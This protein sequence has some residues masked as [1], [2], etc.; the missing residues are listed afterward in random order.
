MNAR[1]RIASNYSLLLFFIIIQ[2]STE[3]GCQIR[4]TVAMEY[5]CTDHRVCLIRVDWRVLARETIGHDHLGHVD[6]STIGDGG[7]NSSSYRVE[8]ENAQTRFALSS[9]S[10]RLSE[11]LTTRRLEANESMW[12]S[13]RISE[14]FRGIV[15]NKSAKQASWLRVLQQI[16]IGECGAIYVFL[17]EPTTYIIWTG[18]SYAWI[19]LRISPRENVW[20]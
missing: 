19:K 16:Y 2:A 17:S 10:R 18:P 11:N 9:F 4:R 8:P 20:N 5:Y 14:N 15:R 7:S 12:E 6:Y 3:V 1:I 13:Q